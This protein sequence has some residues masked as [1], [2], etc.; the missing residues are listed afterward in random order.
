MWWGLGS[1][2]WMLLALALADFHSCSL[3]MYDT[4]TY[5]QKN[6]L[7]IMT[8]QLNQVTFTDLGDVVDLE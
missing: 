3:S 5:R 6:D 8:K 1:D 7:V 4:Q 2:Q